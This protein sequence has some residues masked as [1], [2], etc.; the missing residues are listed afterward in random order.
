MKNIGHNFVELKLIYE[1]K[2]FLK[3]FIVFTL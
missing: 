2:K 1:K 3:N